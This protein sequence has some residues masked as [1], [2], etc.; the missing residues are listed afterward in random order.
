MG[1]PVNKCSQPQNTWWVENISSFNMNFMISI[2]TLTW[3]PFPL[4]W[5]G[6][7]LICLPQVV[8][9]T[10]IPCQEFLVWVWCEDNWECQYGLSQRSFSQ[11]PQHSALLQKRICKH[12][13]KGMLKVSTYTYFVMS[14]TLFQGPQ[15]QILSPVGL[16]IAFMSFIMTKLSETNLML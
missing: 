7:L 5:V 15:N 6:R 12:L 2:H 10:S 8:Q 14:W 9:T 1:W 13:F 3:S 16:T 11:P 4:P